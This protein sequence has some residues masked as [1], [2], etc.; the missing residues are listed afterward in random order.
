MWRRGAV[1]GRPVVV[2]G[3]RLQVDVSEFDRGDGGRRAA[4]RRRPARR[5]VAAAALLWVEQQRPLEPVEAI[6]ARHAHVGGGGGQG[7]DGDADR[8]VDEPRQVERHRRSAG[9]H[10]RPASNAPRTNASPR[11]PRQ[12]IDAAQ[13]AHLKAERA[14][15]KI[16]I[17]YTQKLGEVFSRKKIF[18]LLSYRIT[19]NVNIIVKHLSRIMFVILILKW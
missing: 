2:A 9:G 7:D 3:A 14:D 18:D 6:A 5:L 15:S 13:R 12:R 19:D 16:I 17:L 11:H 4:R 8:R 1:D 10:P